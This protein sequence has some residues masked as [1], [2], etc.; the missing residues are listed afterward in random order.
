MDLPAKFGDPSFM[1]SGKVEISNQLIALPNMV[2]L[3][4][5]N[6]LIM[7]PPPTTTTTTH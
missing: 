7:T 6:K 5:W 2:S 3:A 4:H 1:G